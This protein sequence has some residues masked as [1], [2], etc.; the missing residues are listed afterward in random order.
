MKK[1]EGAINKLDKLLEAASVERDPKR[2]RD[3]ATKKAE[4][5]RRLSEVEEEWLDLSESVS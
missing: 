3:L 4:F 1:A 5:E 2:I